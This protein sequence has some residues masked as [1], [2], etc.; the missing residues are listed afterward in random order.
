M[1]KTHLE[2]YIEEVYPN[3]KTELKKIDF[4]STSQKEMYDLYVEGIC[5]ERLIYYPQSDQLET[6][7]VKYW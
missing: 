4:Q 1:K 6:I 7:K 5:K 2:F 3:K